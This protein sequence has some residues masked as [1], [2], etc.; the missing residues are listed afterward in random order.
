MSEAAPR[1]AA[2]ASSEVGAVA[3]SAFDGGVPNEGG[4]AAD[5][6]ALKESLLRYLFH[7]LDKA[8]FELYTVR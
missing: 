2:E 3:S 8:M 7:S 6:A 4:A 5:G 1:A